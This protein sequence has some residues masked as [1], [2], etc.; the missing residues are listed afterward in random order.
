MTEAVLE[1]LGPSGTRRVPI[2]SFYRGYK[3]ID[4]DDDELLARVETRLPASDQELRLYKMSRRRDMDISSFSAA[5]LLR[6]DGDRITRAR[7]AFGG[8]AETVVRMQEAEN[9]L[10]G[11]DL[12]EENM[13]R[14]GSIAAAAIE[15]ITDVRGHS[16]YR[17]RL[18]E[19]VMLKYFF[20]VREAVTCV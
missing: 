18:A 5:I 2:E 17:L 7:I 19:N 10:V 12:S 3:D 15:P 9:Y 11:R 8:V 1:I 14:A 13:L 16:S 6:L 4:L 20:D